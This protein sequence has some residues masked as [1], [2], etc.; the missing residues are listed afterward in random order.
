MRYLAINLAAL[1]APK[2]I[3]PLLLLS[4]TPVILA[5]RPAVVAFKITV[6]S[7]I[8]N[9]NGVIYSAPGTP[10]LTNLE[11]NNDA[12]P[13]ATIPRG[14]TQLINNLSFTDMVDFPVL[15]KTP[16]GLSMSMMLTNNNKTLQSYSNSRSC[17][18]IFAL[19][20]MNNI[21]IN[22]I[23]MDSPK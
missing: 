21:A 23:L 20:S 6:P 13:A 15:K 9:T 19:K 5:T 12:I 10:S 2:I 1:C 17:M 22:N 7:T 3:I 16:N 14:P 18:L 8:I 4:N 11:P